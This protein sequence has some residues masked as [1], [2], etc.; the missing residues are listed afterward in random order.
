M[1]FKNPYTRYTSYSLCPNIT[2]T[3]HQGS[4]FA[5]SIP[6]EVFSLLSHSH[7]GGGKETRTPDI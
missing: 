4:L 2:L 1:D 5:S 7:F 6:L 3:F